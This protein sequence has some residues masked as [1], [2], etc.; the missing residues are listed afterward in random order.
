MKL[1]YV[2]DDD[3]KKMTY[4]N[5]NNQTIKK[6]CRKCECD[7]WRSDV[8]YCWDCYKYEMYESR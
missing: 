1:K 7:C 8:S 4:K 2:G 5:L 3:M 6:K